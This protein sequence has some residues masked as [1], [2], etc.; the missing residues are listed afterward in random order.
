MPNG[1]LEYFEIGDLGLDPNIVADLYHQTEFEK[2]LK[3]LEK[4]GHIDQRATDETNERLII[5]KFTN[6]VKFPGIDE[7]N[8]RKQIMILVCFFF[9]GCEYSHKY[10]LRSSPHRNSE[11]IDS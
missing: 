4:N 2:L 11:L 6:T 3:R 1:E 7:E 10:S 5:S 9:T 8:G